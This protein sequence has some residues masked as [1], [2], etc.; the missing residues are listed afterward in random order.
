MISAFQEAAISVDP[1]S[2]RHV[3]NN[4]TNNLLHEIIPIPI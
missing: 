4:K 1:Y 2:A 3:I